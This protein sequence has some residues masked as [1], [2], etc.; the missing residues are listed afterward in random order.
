M[1]NTA[2]LMG[3]AII[4]T[5]ST[6]FTRVIANKS[7][8]KSEMNVTNDKENMNHKHIYTH[9]WLELTGPA[10]ELIPSIDRRGGTRRR[11]R[12]DSLPWGRDLWLG[13]N[14][15]RVL[16]VEE[17]WGSLIRGLHSHRRASPLP[18]R[19]G[20]WWQLPLDSYQ[21]FACSILINWPSHSRGPIWITPLGAVT[22]ATRW[23]RSESRKA[24]LKCIRLTR[25]AVFLKLMKNN[26]EYK[27]YESNQIYWF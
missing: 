5:F 2:D 3:G 27:K 12:G 22:L 23:G 20:L 7:W 24:S 8:R 17:F 10:I 21:S 9:I 13:L 25:T 18:L 6:C 1:M 15:R 11:W 26:R 16:P 4:L 19:R 14:G